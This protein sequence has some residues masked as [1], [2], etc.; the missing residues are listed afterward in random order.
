MLE[1]DNWLSYNIQRHMIRCLLWWRAE[2]I[3]FWYKLNDKEW[4]LNRETNM[5]LMKSFNNPSSMYVHSTFHIRIWRPGPYAAHRPTLSTL[6]ETNQ[7]FHFS[8]AST[9]MHLFC[10]TQC[11]TTIYI[12]IYI[13]IYI[14]YI[15]THTYIY[16]D[17]HTQPCFY[18]AE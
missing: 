14:L 9:L 1:L 2:W 6:Q 13:Y 18:T 3:S 12:Y 8:F 15:H 7:S 10:T 11:C 16:I 17:M 5:D 4:A